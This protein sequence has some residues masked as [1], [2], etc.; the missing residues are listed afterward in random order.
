MS[1]KLRNLTVETL[2]DKFIKVEKIDCEYK[3]KN[4][5]WKPMSREILVR[6]DAVA[7]LLYDPERRKLLLTRQFRMP[8]YRNNP[9]DAMITEV[10]AG[11]LDDNDPETAVLKEIEEET[12]FR[13]SPKDLNKIY[14]AY[15]S[16]GTTTEYL[17]Y[18]TGRYNLAQQV[19]KGG[20]AQDENED[21]TVL[22]WSYEMAIAAMENGEIKDLKMLMLLQYAQMH[23]F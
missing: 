14:E 1:D 9:E 11:M 22:E 6:G 23:L 10:C 15:S 20:G 4:G 7:V 18:F 13:L 12:G 19:N 3:N 17:H 2:V 16:C 5:E 8:V 21:I